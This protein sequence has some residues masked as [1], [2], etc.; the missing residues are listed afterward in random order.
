MNQQDHDRRSLAL[1]QRVCKRLRVDSSLPDQ[2]RRIMRRWTALG[3]QR[4]ASAAAHWRALLEAGDVDALITAACAPGERGDQLR[5]ASPHS[6]RLAPREQWE[7]L[8]EWKA[9]DE[10]G[11]LGLVGETY[12]RS[13]CAFAD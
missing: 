8:S 7:F 2:A 5:Q 10:R 11:R 3:D 4:A 9:V 1:H 13:T 12:A 6:C